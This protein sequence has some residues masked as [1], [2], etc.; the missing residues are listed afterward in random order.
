MER[1]GLARADVLAIMAAQTSRDNRLAA[2]DDV[3][4]NTGSRA[5]LAAQVEILHALYLKKA[6]DKSAAERK[7][8]F[9]S[10]LGAV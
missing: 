10:E 2:A 8:R 4:E 9:N 5:E 1:S 6:G 3:I 7:M